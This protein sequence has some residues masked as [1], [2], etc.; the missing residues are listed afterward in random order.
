[1]SIYSSI[2]CLSMIFLHVSFEYFYPIVK[3]NTSRYFRHVR[4]ISTA[5]NY[6]SKS[7][8]DLDSCNSMSKNSDSKLECLVKNP[9]FFDKYISNDPNR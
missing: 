6:E 8:N 5:A 1:M 3:L 4:S 9:S 2:L 7:Q